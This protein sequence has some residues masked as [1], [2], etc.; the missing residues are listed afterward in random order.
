MKRVIWTE[1]LKYRAQLRGFKLEL[2]EQVALFSE[3]RYFDSATQ[4]MVAVGR[5]GSQLVMIPYDQEGETVTPVTV[6]FTTRQQ[7]NVRLRTDRFKP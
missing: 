7:I 4:R 6:H 1:Y 2:I 3:E 5:Y